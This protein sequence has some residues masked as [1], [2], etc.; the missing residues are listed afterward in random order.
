MC[1]GRSGSKAG[2]GTVTHA[3]WET[4][5]ASVGPD[6]LLSRALR[7]LNRGHRCIAHIY[8]SRQCSSHLQVTCR[9]NEATTR[10]NRSARHLSLA[11]TRASSTHPP[12][13]G[14]TRRQATPN[15][16][17][18]ARAPRALRYPLPGSSFIARLQS[19]CNYSSSAR[20]ILFIETLLK[21]LGIAGEHALHDSDAFIGPDE[22]LQAARL[23]PVSNLAP[24]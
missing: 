15:P 18:R 24:V 1:S 16:P 20:P 2:F 14:Y 12:S 10:G 7:A 21:L 19:L 3:S 22:L 11:I 4:F 5:R 13:P 8:S 6:A 23:T 9:T 17:K